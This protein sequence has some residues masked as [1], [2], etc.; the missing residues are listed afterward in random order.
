MNSIMISE[1]AAVSRATEMLFP[2][3]LRLYEDN[4][5]IEF[6]TSMNRFYLFIMKSKILRQWILNLSDRMAPGVYGGI[7]S[8]TKYMDDA[9]TFAIENGFEAIVNLGAGY[10]T[11]CLRFDMKGIAYYHV[12]QGPVIDSFKKTV[13]K[14]DSGI[15]RNVIFVPI[16]FNEQILENELIKAGYNQSMKTLFIWEGVTQYITKNAVDSTLE[17]IGMTRKGSRV[18]F[19][20]VVKGLL[21]NPKTFPKYKG[22]LKQIK[23]TGAQWLTGFESDDI[24]NYLKE[25][26]LTLIEDVG[27]K[28]YQKRYFKPINR[29]VEIMTI[30]R[31]A[32]AEV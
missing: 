26:G 32:Y 30:E 6:L 19:T 28:E 7:I 9:L 21:D 23:L 1:K 27:E 8:R 17:F 16:D 4:F 24:S 11:K 20:Y 3:E 25:K 10:D 5:S 18:V 13:S 29:E 22:L 15:P 2:K 12:D 31:I 14:L